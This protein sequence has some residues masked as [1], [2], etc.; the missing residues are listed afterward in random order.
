MNTRTLIQTAAIVFALAVVAPTRGTVT[1]AGQHDHEQGQTAQ[2]GQGD[3]GQMKKG[4]M[5]GQMNMDEMAAKQKAS[6]ERLAVLMDQIKT[7]KGDAKVAA[8]AETIALLVDERAA[9]QQHCA[10]MMAK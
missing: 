2:S 9:M 5:M 3:A 10:S 8:M 1:A 7:S 6:T 4:H